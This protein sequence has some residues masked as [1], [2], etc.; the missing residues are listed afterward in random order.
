MRLITDHDGLRQW[1]EGRGGAPATYVETRHGA[2]PGEL[3]IHF[4]GVNDEGVEDIDW[5][6]FFEKFEHKHLALLCEDEKPE[7]EPTL[8]FRFTSRVHPKEGVAEAAGDHA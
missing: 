4:P 7:G 2:A 5:Q 3:T 6:S 8:D 1:V